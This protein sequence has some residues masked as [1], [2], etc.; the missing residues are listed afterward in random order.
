MRD[1][2]RRKPIYLPIHGGDR[3][4]GEGE[5]EETIT[6]WC[7]GRGGGLKGMKCYVY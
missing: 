1:K 3:P 4:M 5:G 7:M 6:V 2:G